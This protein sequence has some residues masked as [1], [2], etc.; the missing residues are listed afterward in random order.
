MGS[1]SIWHL[2][3][4]AALGLSVIPAFLPL[5]IKPSGPN[6]FGPS[7]EPRTFVS[8]V[9]VCLQKYVDGN[10]RAKR[11]E[12]WWFY[13]AAVLV[14]F[15]LSSVDRMVGDTGVVTLL[16]WAYVLPVLL[17]GVRRLHDINRSGWWMLLMFT[18]V[19]AIT[20][21]VLLV[22]PSQKDETAEVF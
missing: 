11:S 5:L 20:L 8:A 3:F 15:A 18:G 19:G 10:G 12:Y 21:L 4:V 9:T 14:S 22:W 13:L 6:R 16:T 1:F 2:L 7:P 17:A